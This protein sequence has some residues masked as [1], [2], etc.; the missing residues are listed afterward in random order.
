M[1]RK[2]RIRASGSRPI[3]RAA[4]SRSVLVGDVNDVIIENSLIRIAS[5]FSNL[6]SPIGGGDSAQAAPQDVTR[7]REE[8]R[9]SKRRF[10]F[11]AIEKPAE[12]GAGEGHDRAP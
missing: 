10:V 12:A 4:L 11:G 5:V 7:N 8:R 2:A 3:A 6:L 9:D 1:M